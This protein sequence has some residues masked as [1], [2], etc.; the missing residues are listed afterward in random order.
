MRHLSNSF[1]LLFF[2]FVFN[3]DYSNTFG[4]SI[5]V[6]YPYPSFKQCDHDATWK[7][8]IIDTKTLCSVGSFIASLAMAL[9]GA[10]VRIPLTVNQA[11]PAEI[12]T[13][14]GR[15]VKVSS[16]SDALPVVTDAVTP[17]TLVNWLRNNQGMIIFSK[18]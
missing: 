4:T 2:Q 3:I 7:N 11:G 17:K 8:E 5:T 9:S 18:M 15:V 6:P 12:V 16:S 1:L 10:G 14:D 13:S